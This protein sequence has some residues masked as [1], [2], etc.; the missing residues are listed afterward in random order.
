[1]LGKTVLV[2]GAAKRVGRAIAGELHAA[3]ANVVVHYRH[4]A[5]AAK[6]VV[7][8]FNAVRAGSA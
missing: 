2:T 8:E 3:G 7:D 6:T 1:M 4:A 5:E